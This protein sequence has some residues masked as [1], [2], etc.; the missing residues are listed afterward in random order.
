MTIKNNLLK[1]ILGVYAG[2]MLL[3]IIFLTLGFIDSFL[4]RSIT[5]P[6]SLTT[7]Y[8]IS[9]IAAINYGINKPTQLF[10]MSVFGGM[11]ARMLLILF[12]VFVSIKFFDINLWIYIFV[13]FVTYFFYLITEVVYLNLL[14]TKQLK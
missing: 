9:G 5:L 8:F 10:L 11:V 12:L 7:I 2:I 3:S 13:L 6:Y 4:W 1:Y 14:K